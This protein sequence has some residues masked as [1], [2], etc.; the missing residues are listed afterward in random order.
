MMGGKLI[1]LCIFTFLFRG[2]KLILISI[3]AVIL[4]STPSWYSFL[5][6][7]YEQYLKSPSFCEKYKDDNSF[8]VC[9]YNLLP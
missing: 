9:N 7:K 6:G 2:K 5:Y 1:G 4:A 3:F 8:N